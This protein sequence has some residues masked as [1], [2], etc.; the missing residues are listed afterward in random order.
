MLYERNLRNYV[1]LSLMRSEQDLTCLQ[2]LD[3]VKEV[4]MN[5]T[6]LYKHRCLSQVPTRNCKDLTEMSFGFFL[7]DEEFVS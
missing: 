7:R 3:Q 5:A 6:M 1:N 2:A 4:W